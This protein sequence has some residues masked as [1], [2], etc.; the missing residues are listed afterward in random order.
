MGQV[1]RMCILLGMSAYSYAVFGIAAGSVLAAGAAV[2]GLL[3]LFA[4]RAGAK[5]A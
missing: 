5:A 4:F 2:L 1:V 3:A